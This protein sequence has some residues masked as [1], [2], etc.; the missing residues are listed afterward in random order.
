MFR[1]AHASE[2]Q[3][4]SWWYHVATACYSKDEISVVRGDRV[5]DV[6]AV[7]AHVLTAVPDIDVAVARSTN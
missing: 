6:E 1:A 4:P 7:E 2:A 5:I 3:E